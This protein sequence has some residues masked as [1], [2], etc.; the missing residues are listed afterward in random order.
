MREQLRFFGGLSG[1]QIADV[2]GVDRATVVRD[3]ATARAWL[4]SSLAP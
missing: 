3:W 4:S 1:E 2:L